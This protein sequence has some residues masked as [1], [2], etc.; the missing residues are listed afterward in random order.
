MRAVET[1]WTLLHAGALGDLVLGIQLALRLPGATTAETLHVVSRTN[2]GD[3]SR[4]RPQVAR[5]SS[6]GLGLHW[7]FGDHDDPPPAPLT[8]LIQNARILSFLGGPHTLAHQRLLELRPAAAFGVDPRPRPAGTRHVVDQWQTQLETQ[9]LLVP[10]CTHQQ[11]Q[12]RA[13]GVPPVA[14]APGSLCRA[15]PPILIHPG[16]GGMHKCWPRASFADVARRLCPRAPL[17]DARQTA[18]RNAQRQQALASAA[19]SDA[20]RGCGNDHAVV[21]LLG[22]VELETWP[23]R[24]IDAIAADFSV[25]CNPTPD[26]L[27]ALLAG[28][29]ALLANDAGPAHLAALLGTPIVALF[30]PTPAAVWRPLG[31]HVTVF[32]GNPGQPRNW[33]LSTTAVAA[34]VCDAVT[35]HL[36]SA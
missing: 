15:P 18:H 28:A 23:A 30:G 1:P 31:P 6:E 22:P 5:R 20:G 10:K 36:P 2:P 8:A 14:G 11:P 17:W 27:V 13:L 21:W 24:D 25:V 3:L 12:R 32:Q 7:L 16:S 4:C 33:G 19:R 9:G 29:A 26:E 34:A 35:A